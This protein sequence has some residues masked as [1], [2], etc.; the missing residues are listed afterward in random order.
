MCEKCKIP[1]CIKKFLCNHWF[2]IGIIIILLGTI[3]FCLVPR[4]DINENYAGIVLGFVGILATFIVVSN[5]AQVKDIENKFET[6]IKDLK[7][8]NQREMYY[9]SLFIV[10]AKDAKITILL[11]IEQLL[12]FI[13]SNDISN[14]ENEINLIRNVC[15]Y[16]TFSN[17]YKETKERIFVL[18]SNIQQQYKIQ[19]DVIKDYLNRKPNTNTFGTIHS[20]VFY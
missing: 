14:I 11:N 4:I 16:N 1:N 7:K 9:N 8:E 15:E 2:W 12:I 3:L 13:E 19:T 17:E 10:S 6:K 5:Y 18:L 20:D